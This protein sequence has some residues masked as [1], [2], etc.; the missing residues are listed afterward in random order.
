MSTSD[1]FDIKQI[2]RFSHGNHAMQKMHLIAK[3]TLSNIKKMT[4]LEKLV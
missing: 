3:F 1:R 2:S 4:S